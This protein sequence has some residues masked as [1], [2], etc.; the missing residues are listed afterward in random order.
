MAVLARLTC[1]R[2]GRRPAACPRGPSSVHYPL[3]LP[4]Y[5]Y[6]YSM[7]QLIAESEL[8]LNS[9]RSIYHLN[10]LPEDIA[11]TIVL[12][13]D[14]ERVP[15]VS[16]YFDLIDVKKRKREFVTHT[17]YL[18]N[19]RISAVSTG[20]GTDNID[21]VLNELD[22]LVNIDFATRKI[23]PNLTSL[24][25]VRLGTSGAL[26]SE[27]ALDSF[28]VSTF[29][30]GFD[31]LMEFYD[32]EYTKDEETLLAAA[33][34]HFLPL[35][36][37]YMAKGNEALVQQFSQHCVPGITATCPGFYGPQGRVLRGPTKEKDFIERMHSFRQDGHRITNFEMETSG[38]YGLG[39]LLGHQCCSIN[40][41]VANR[42]TQQF[43]SDAYAAVE[44]MIQM[45]LPVLVY[46]V[47]DTF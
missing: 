11:D 6:F 18:N 30:L 41:I 45:A 3:S 32:L 7:P 37:F 46:S 47:P 34:T 16:K 40:T 12:V 22:A 2:D 4:P 36:P 19:K 24:K 21:I 20:I 29:G 1:P 44:R 15:M 31:C 42:I 23:K 25:L 28:V 8:I 26:Q 10:I 14:P 38:I 17:G 35:F 13:G 43:S 27:I 39:R 33:R 5:G 9:D